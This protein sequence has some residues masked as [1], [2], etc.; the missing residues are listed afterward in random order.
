L[1][2]KFIST[3]GILRNIT[4]RNDFKPPSLDLNLQVAV[5][6]QMIYQKNSDNFDPFN[7]H[8]V[9]LW[10]ILEQFDKSISQVDIDTCSD[11]GYLL[12][13]GEKSYCLLYP[14]HYN[15]M[16]ELDKLPLTFAEQVA[17]RF[18]T[19]YLA[20]L[21]EFFLAEGL[22]ENQPHVFKYSKKM[23][24][25]VINSEKKYQGRKSDSIV[26]LEDIDNPKEILGYVFKVLPDLYGFGMFVVFITN[27]NRSGV[28][29]DW[30]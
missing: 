23:N 16:K 28:Y 24:T 5:V 22:A 21:Y 9:A 27:M 7:Q 30:K 26:Y 11:K 20:E 12:E 15:Q 4:E 19:G 2:K 3:G 14:S 17:L 8:C 10:E 29:Y 18:P 1:K 13:K 6:W 25:L